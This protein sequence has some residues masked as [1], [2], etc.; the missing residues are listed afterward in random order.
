MEYKVSMLPDKG[1]S[2]QQVMSFFPSQWESKCH[3]LGAL[4]R[5]REFKG[6]SALM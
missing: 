5:V 2:W 3:E 1:D 6:P 4:R